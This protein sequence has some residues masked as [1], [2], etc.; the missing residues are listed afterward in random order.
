M[1]EKTVH[2]IEELRK[3]NGLKTNEL[4]VKLGYSN[5]AFGKALEANSSI[6][7]EKILLLLEVFPEVDLNWLITGKGSMLRDVEND[8]YNA[9]NLALYFS[10]NHEKLKKESELYRVRMENLVKDEIILRYKNEKKKG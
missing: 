2:R 3:K 10:K 9:D 7:D 4:E 6:K 1:E 5:G 8:P